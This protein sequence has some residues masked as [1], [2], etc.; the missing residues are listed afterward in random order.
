MIGMVMNLFGCSFEGSQYSPEQVIQNALAEE[1]KVASYYGEAELIFKEA[2][3]V[4]EHM[5][6]KEWRSKDG[7]IKIET[8]QIDGGDETIS[9]YNGKEFTVL[10]VDKNEAFVSNDEEL[11]SDFQPSMKEQAHNMLDMIRDSHEISIEGEEK[12]AGRET[13]HLV[14][15][16]KD[17]K[18]LF[19]DQ[20]LW[21]DKENWIVL[22]IFSVMGDHEVEMEHKKIDFDQEMKDEIF[23]LDLPE[24]VEIRSFDEISESTEV[25]LEEA[26]ENIGQPLLYF[27]EANGLEI[28]SID[29]LEVKGEIQRTEVN[30]DYEKDGL[31]SFTLTVFPADEEDEEDYKL[32]GEESI[33]IRDEKG[34]VMDLDEF[35]S[36][37]W[38]ENGLTYSVL[39]T[40]PKLSIEEF[41]KM[42]ND[43]E[44]VE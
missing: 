16:E 23:T 6:L 36:I 32:P 34:T 20:E 10:Q 30:I 21:I 18:T 2:G 37:V 39:L 27:P 13:Y 29:L 15:K 8:A 43:M 24:D 35:R 22:K 40:D 19:G 31:A 33:D 4:S 25:S 28:A 42:A 12:I 14:A 9:V 38:T 5:R 44:L 7:K 17:E 41:V 3:E 1:E 26:I 11:L